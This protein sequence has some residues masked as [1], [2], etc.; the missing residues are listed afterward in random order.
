MLD[1]NF[2]VQNLPSVIAKLEKRQ[3]NFAYLNKLPLLAQQRKSL[4]LEIQDLRSQKNQSAKKV[5]QKANAKEDITLVLQDTNFLRDD[6][7]KLEQKLKLKEQEIFDIL[8]ITPNLP[9]DS[10]PIG[11]NDKDNKELYCAGQIRTFAFTPK[12]HV[13]LAEKLDILDFK[14]ASKI[15]GSG[16]VV[17]KGL[18]ARL[19][20]ALIQ[21]MMDLHNKKGYQEIIPPYIINEK[22]MFATGQ[23]PKFE[24]EV[25]KL[26]NSKNNW[27]LNPTAEVPTIN[28]HREEIFKPDTLPIKYVAYTTAFRQEAGSAGKDTRGIFRQHQFNKV[29]LIQFCHPQNSYECLDQMLKDS[30]EVLKLLKLPYR[31]VLL[32]TGDLGFSMAKTYD[33]EVFLPSYNC[34][35]EIGSISNS[36]DF[37]AR[38]ANI[39][40]KNPANNKNEYVHILNGSGLAVGRTVIAIL[41]N[42][43]NQDGTITVP[44][45]LQPYLGTD[46]IK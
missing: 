21:F 11:T 7:Q 31:V 38:R 25:Y 6:L 3:Q 2:V 27:Y 24:D 4:L 36:C 46:I 13:Y 42:Y 35:R 9:H 23:L 20:R 40:M 12:D 28:L 44:E 29:E 37:Q 39:K 14:R 5:A 30:E 1:L 19:E 16:F 45:V 10:L 22:S 43:Q 26:Y 15:S 32:S 8:S 18:G 34:Y 33:L 17:C 41:E